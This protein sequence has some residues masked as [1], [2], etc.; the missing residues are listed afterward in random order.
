MPTVLLI[1]HGR[2]AANATG[3][4]AG[5]TPGIVLDDLGRSQAG[6]LADR[7]GAL[8]VRRLV[9]SPLQRCQETAEILGDRW[10]LAAGV[11]QDL[12]EC[13]YGAWTGRPITELAEESLWRTVQDHP[14]AAR[15]P[16]S[17]EHESES[18]AQMQSRAVAAVRR[19]DAEVEAQDG[20]DALW[21]LVSHGDVIKSIVAD[22]VGAHLDH[23]QRILVGPASLSVIRYT[24]RRPFLALLGDQGADLGWLT[25]APTSAAEVPAG[26]APVGGGSTHPG[27]ECASSD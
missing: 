26:D 19:V 11:M 18:L 16:A 10:G 22:A 1:R 7:I 20:P 12:G 15:F 8:P 3:T 9:T 24:S 21:S 4:L 6:A 23:F 25:P 14:S 17:D 5:W 2:T 13:R 27:G